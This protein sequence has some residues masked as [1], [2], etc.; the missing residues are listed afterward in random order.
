MRNF[1]QLFVILV[2][3]FFNS[4]FAQKSHSVNHAFHNAFVFGLDGGVTIPQSDYE[5]SKIGYSARLSGEYFFKTNSIHLLGLKLKIGS[6]E[7]RGEDSRDTISSQDDRRGIPP[8]FVTSI[9]SVG[10]A[11]TYSISVANVFFPYV[12]GGYKY[13]V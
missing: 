1:L 5:K 10:I 11:A 6:E 8:T 12:S 13:V 7:V 2:I 4:T 3:L 9:F